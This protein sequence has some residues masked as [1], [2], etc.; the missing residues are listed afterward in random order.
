MRSI[1]LMLLIF[2]GDVE[3]NP[4]P[5]GSSP[6]SPTATPDTSCISTSAAPVQSYI[7]P[8]IPELGPINYWQLPTSHTKALHHQSCQY[9]H[10]SIVHTH[11]GGGQFFCACP[12]CKKQVHI[13]LKICKYCGFALQ[14]LGRSAGTNATAGFDVSSGR[15]TGTNIAT[16]FK[17]SSGRPVGTTAARGSKVGHSP[18]R[19]KGTTEA[20]GSH[21]SVG[22]GRPVV[23][24]E[25][26][27]K[28]KL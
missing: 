2:A 28:E 3:L 27:N 24:K 11:R 17:V 18:G 15:P 6:Y 16:G 4:G 12:S 13:R 14:R 1:A 8:S 22:G 25:G 19:P 10:T 26:V 23:L 21:T 7:L 20:A 5:T 9:T